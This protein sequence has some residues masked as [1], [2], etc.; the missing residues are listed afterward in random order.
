MI[1]I[2]GKPCLEHIVK[3]LEDIGILEIIIKVNYKKE[4]VI[5]HFGERVMYY[6]QPD[7][8]DEEESLIDMAKWLWDD[9]TLVINGDTLS[10]VDISRMH[11]LAVNRNIRHMDRK[12]EGLYAGTKILTPE[13]WKGDRTFTDFFSTDEWHDIGTWTGLFKARR[14]YEKKATNLL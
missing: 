4:Q 2:A 7:L 9:Y 5:E 1:D 8:K 6:Y 12:V 11:K 13:Y 14:F 10:D 3:K